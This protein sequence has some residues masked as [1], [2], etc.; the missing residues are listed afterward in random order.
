MLFLF[1]L[2]PATIFGILGF[3]VLLASDKS[4]Q[5]VRT[6]GKGLAIWILVLALIPPI[7]GAYMSFSGNFSMAE[8]TAEM[9]DS[10]M[11]ECAAKMAQAMKNIAD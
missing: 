3:L 2:I 4:S 6:F 10:H 5:G 1:S 9:M 11:E 7:G 8:M